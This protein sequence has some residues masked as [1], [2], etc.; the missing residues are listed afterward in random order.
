MSSQVSLQFGPNFWEI[1]STTI[2]A[3]FLGCPSPLI[4][5]VTESSLSPKYSL[6]FS[7]QPSSFS[8]PTAAAKKQVLHFSP[9]PLQQPSCFHSHPPLVLSTIHN[10]AKLTMTVPSMRLHT[11]LLAVVISVMCSFYIK[12]SLLFPLYK[13]LGLHSIQNLLL[14]STS[15]SD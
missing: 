9:G 2:Q 12:K 6:N 15:P 8:T 10:A 4:Q 3:F 13:L 7:S 5:V 14:Y 1:N 11:K